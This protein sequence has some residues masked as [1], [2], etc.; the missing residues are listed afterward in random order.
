[1]I[2]T[3]KTKSELTQDLIAKVLKYDSTT[4]VL[5]WTTNLHSKRVVPNSRAGTLKPSGYRQVS[6]LGGTYLEHHLIWFIQTGQWPT[7]QIDH[8]DQVRDN[9]AWHNLRQVTKAE[10][11]RNRTRNPNSKLGEHGIWLNQ[12][13]N[14]Y[15]AEITLN[16]KKVY[17]KSFDDIDE[18]IEARKAKSLEL[19]FHENHGSKPTGK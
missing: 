19:G 18:A 12:R 6:L 13:T 10:N 3:K 9:N 17:Q 8:I 15:V 14:K 2:F 7:G 5:I 11:A 1:M 4:G 16:G